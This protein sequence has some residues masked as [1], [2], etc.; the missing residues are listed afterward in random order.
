M[1]VAEVDGNDEF[2][3]CC[4]KT[5]VEAT[6]PAIAVSRTSTESR[7]ALV[8]H[9]IGR[10]RRGDVRKRS[11]VIACNRSDQGRFWMFRLY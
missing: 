6:M 10:N 1:L 3:G 4:A 7:M 8:Y 11:G 2:A 9:S 5:R